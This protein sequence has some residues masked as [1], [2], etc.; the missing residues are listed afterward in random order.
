MDRRYYQHTDISPYAHKEFWWKDM[1]KL[2]PL[3]RTFTM[4]IIGS[5]DTTLVWKD[6]W[7]D[8]LLESKWS[9]LIWI[10]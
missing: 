2:I 7:I 6:S 5:A 8:S 10:R 1:F 9:T 4:V 3:F